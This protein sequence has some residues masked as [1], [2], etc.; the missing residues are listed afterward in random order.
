M[1]PLA[2]APL[3]VNTGL[4]ALKIGLESIGGALT[5]SAAVLAVTYAGGA[6]GER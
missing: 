1:L 4:P 2:P 3:Q 6:Q 5:G